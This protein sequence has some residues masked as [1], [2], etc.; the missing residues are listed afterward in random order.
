M[1]QKYGSK[2]E[3]SSCDRSIS[4][5]EETISVTILDEKENVEIPLQIAC[6]TFDLSRDNSRTRG[7]GE[8]VGAKSSASFVL[9]K[10]HLSYVIDTVARKPSRVYAITI[11]GRLADSFILLAREYSRLCLLPRS[12]ERINFQ[13][14]SARCDEISRFPT[15][16]QLVPVRDSSSA[17]RRRSLRRTRKR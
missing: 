15:K 14:Y 13:L 11:T 12:S 7:R 3:I 8:E 5:R 2:V 9:A 1:T 16:L 6:L 10:S 4:F 17:P